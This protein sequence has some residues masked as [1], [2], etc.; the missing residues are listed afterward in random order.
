MDKAATVRKDRDALTLFQE[1]VGP[2]VPVNAIT[3]SQAVRFSDALAGR[4]LAPNTMNNHMGAVSKFSKWMAGRHPEYR[5]TKLDFS[6]LRY[7]VDKRA[8]EQRDAFTD[9]EVARVLQDSRLARFKTREPHKFWLPYIAAYSGL[10]LEEIAQLDPQTDIREEEG[11]TVFDVNDLSGKQLKNKTSR[12][13]VPVHPALIK[14]G[15]FDYVNELRERRQSRMFPH[16]K[17]RDGRLGKNAAKTV[18]RFIRVKLGIDKTLHCFRHTVATQL[19][20]MRVD[21]AIAA[22]V[23]GHAHGGITYSR[24]G[25]QHLVEVLLDEAVKK[26]G[27]G[28]DIEQPE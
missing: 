18:N 8:D 6:A 21:E 26:I 15:L 7:K 19:K 11:I 17:E 16:T 22:A 20:R 23:L 9:T 14:I 1:V 13:M 25:K 12:R 27:Y 3:Q 24:Y 28:L 5:H 10:R 4:G 2:D